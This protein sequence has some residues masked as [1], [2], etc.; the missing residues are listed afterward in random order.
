VASQG[1][2]RGLKH[3]PQNFDKAEPNSLFRGK[4]IRYNLIR[5][6][7]SLICKLSRTP[8]YGATAPDPRPLCPLF[9][10]EFVEHHPEKIPGYATGLYTR[11]N[12]YLIRREERKLHVLKN[13]KES[14]IFQPKRERERMQQQA[15]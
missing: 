9:S 15:E 12:R 1:G 7:G 3:P 11:N 10:T 14:A 5:I 4:H 6:W 13:R 2:F 8:E